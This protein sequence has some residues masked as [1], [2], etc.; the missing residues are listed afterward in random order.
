MRARG[1]FFST[2]LIAGCSSDVT[3]TGSADQAGSNPNA[4]VQLGTAVLEEDSP[5]LLTQ[6]KIS[7]AAARAV[8]LERFPGSQIVDAEIDQDADRVVY[9]YELRVTE[10]RSVDIDIDAQTGAILAVAEEDED[11]ANRQIDTRPETR[12]AP[13]AAPA[14]RSLRPAR[15]RPRVYI[16]SAPR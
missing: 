9:K 11:E 1:L 10:R 2:L 14:P 8:A 16:A 7:D 15:Q 4:T 5:G 13:S 12:R 6:A 3:T